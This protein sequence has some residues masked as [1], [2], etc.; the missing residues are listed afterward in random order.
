[1]TY[2]GRI[3]REKDL[4]LLVQAWKLLGR[5]KDAKLVLVGRGPMENELNRRRIPGLILTGVKHDLDLAAAYASSDVF[6]FPSTTETFGNVLLE[7]MASG[8]PCLAAAAGGVMEFARHQSNAWLVQPHSTEAIATGL[9]RLLEDYELRR[10]LSAGARLT[11]SR[12]G[13]ESVFDSLLLEYHQ[14]GAK[15]QPKAA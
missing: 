7:G 5:R 15:L 14:A 13:W 12:R 1:M 6:A 3:A 9:E 4:D 8:L 2:V 11:A 10:E